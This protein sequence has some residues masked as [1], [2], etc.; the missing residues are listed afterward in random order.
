MQIPSRCSIADDVRW[1]VG[2]LFAVIVCIPLV[3]LVL[4]LAIADKARSMIR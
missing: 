2:T 3:P 1:G 4:A